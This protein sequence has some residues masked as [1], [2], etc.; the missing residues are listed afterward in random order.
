M[1]VL[2]IC[3]KLRQYSKRMPGSKQLEFPGGRP[4]AYTVLSAIAWC[5]F[6]TNVATWCLIPKYWSAAIP[7]AVHSVATRFNGVTFYV[8]PTSHWLLKWSFVAS[9][10][11]IVA[12]ISLGIYY[13][14]TGAARPRKEI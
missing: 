11:L 14:A 9:L 13:Y 3:R 10:V 4:T 1:P 7:D 2:D 5:V 6:A 8:S 12:S